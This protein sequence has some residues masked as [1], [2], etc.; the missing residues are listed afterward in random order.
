MS[1]GSNRRAGKNARVFMMLQ[2]ESCRRCNPFVQ[3]RRTETVAERHDIAPRNAPTGFGAG[4]VGEGSKRGRMETVAGV[5]RDF[6]H[7]RSAGGPLI[8]GFPAS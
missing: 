3:S 6:G 5:R 1:Y 4:F 2:V 7:F 8:C